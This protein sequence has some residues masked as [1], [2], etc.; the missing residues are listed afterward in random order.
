MDLRQL[1]YFIQAARRQNFRKASEDL[2][3]AQSALT[4]QIQYLERELGFLLFDRVKVRWQADGLSG[5]ELYQFA[6]G[7]ARRLGWELNLDVS[8]HRLADFPHEALYP[9]SLLEATFVPKT[10]LWVLE[11]QIR[12]PQRP[13]GA[14]YEDL[15]V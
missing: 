4:R 3:I 12:H 10:A 11:I 8:G 1:R 9:G 7:E 14:F 13:F 15:L 6:S 5:N 2:R